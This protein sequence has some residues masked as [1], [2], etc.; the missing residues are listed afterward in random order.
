MKVALENA[1]WYPGKVTEDA[2]A[3]I[4]LL[5]GVWRE[6]TLEFHA[7]RALRQRNGGTEPKGVQKFLNQSIDSRFEEAGW[8]GSDGRF[9]RGS[10]WMRV[11]FRHQMSL[12]SDF[13]DA[14]WLSRKE[15]VSQC[16][17]LAAP[18]EFLKIITPNDAGALT[19]Y[20]KVMQKVALL[21][22]IYDVPLILGCLTPQSEVS[23]TIL[24]GLTGARPRGRSSR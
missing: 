22:G 18:L 6:A 8:D 13:L 11:T 2:K 23:T 19:S 20:E 7:I 10:T 12:G 24:E 15:G 17:I 21:N 5:N 16:L 14:L 3:G 9:R 4:S 1:P